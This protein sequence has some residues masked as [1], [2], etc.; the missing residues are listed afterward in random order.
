LVYGGSNNSVRA[1]TPVSGL[2]GIRM[3]IGDTVA[4]V[5]VSDSR[6][7]G[8]GKIIARDPRL[9]ASRLYIIAVTQPRDTC[10]SYLQIFWLTKELR[11]VSARTA[12]W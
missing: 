3:A 4:N 12:V 1:R 6:C 11:L 8:V 7:T 2:I 5:D 9:V 10:H